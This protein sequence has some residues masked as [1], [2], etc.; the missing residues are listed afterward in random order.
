MLLQ[1]HGH[2]V[3][4]APDGRRAVEVAEI[5]RPDVILMDVAMPQLDGLEATR[6]IRLRP[7]GARVR[8]IALTAWGRESERR[9]TLEAGMDL[10]LVK[11]VDPDTLVSLLRQSP[12]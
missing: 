9:R 7:W 6:E 1:A 12:R 4:T 3:L 5:F 2:L 8:I 10:H 11:P